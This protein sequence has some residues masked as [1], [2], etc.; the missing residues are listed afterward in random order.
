MLTGK[1]TSWI[2]VLLFDGSNAQEIV[3]SQRNPYLY[4]NMDGELQYN[5]AELWRNV[6]AG[7]LITNTGE[8]YATE[9]DFLDKYVKVCD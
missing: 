4:R 8:V 3:D 6:E 9:A 5:D 1:Y 7:I 2:T